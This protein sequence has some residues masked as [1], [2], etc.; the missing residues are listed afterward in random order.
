MGKLEM[1]DLPWF[2]VGIQSLREIGMLEWICHLRPLHPYWEGPENIHLTNTLK[3][4]VFLKS[5]MIILYRQDL[6]M[7]TAVNELET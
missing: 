7:G 4:M 3:K 5:S 1:L 6:T 2:N